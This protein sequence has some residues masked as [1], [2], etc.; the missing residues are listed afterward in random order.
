MNEKMTGGMI[1]ESLPYILRSDGMITC[2]MFLCLIII[3]FVLAKEKKYLFHQLKSLLNSRER[4]SMFDD[5][6]IGDVR[7]SILLL[8]HT[9]IL[10]GFCIYFYFSET[11][12]ELFSVVPH[13]Y[14]LVGF[15]SCVIILLLTKWVFYTTI[16]WIFFPKDRN[17]LWME[18][19]SNVM[20]WLGLFMFPVVLLIVYFSLSLQLALYLMGIIIIFAK[21]VL[22]CKYFG[23]FFRKIHG[24]LHL[25][26]YFCAL[27]ILPDLLL[28]KGIR[29]VSNNLILNI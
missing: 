9:C 7:Y 12:P 8:F 6:T 15:I 16:N 21:I 26:L 25:I 1:G 11:L 14:L 10:L 17:V 23:N 24:L 27:E 3:S 2:V 29:I 28:W 18:T 22:I 4:A 5:V 19:Y 20:I 13:G